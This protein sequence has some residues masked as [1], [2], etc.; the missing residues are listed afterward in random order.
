MKPVRR[1]MIR[2]IIV[3][4]NIIVHQLLSKSYDC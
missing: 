1:I 2:E 4:T 3:F